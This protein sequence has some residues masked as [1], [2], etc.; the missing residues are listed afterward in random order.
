MHSCVRWVLLKMMKRRSSHF[1][2]KCYCCVLSFC[3]PLFVYSLFFLLCV[4]C[5]L[6][7][8]RFAF[9]WKSH[10]SS[11]QC[12]HVPSYLAFCFLWCLSD[13]VCHLFNTFSNFYTCTRS[14]SAHYALFDFILDPQNI[15]RIKKKEWSA[16]LLLKITEACR[17]SW[18]ADGLVN[19]CFYLI[20]HWLGEVSEEAE[21]IEEK[22]QKLCNR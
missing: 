20:N 6:L 16:C 21:V 17:I 5:F 19:H 10:S 18:N 13:S 4:A 15:D 3:I 2:T 8:D 12:L 1:Y 22:V 14:E 7:S 9:S 11:G